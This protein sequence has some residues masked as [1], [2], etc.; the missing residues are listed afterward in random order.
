MQSGTETARRRGP[1][2]EGIS[3]RAYEALSEVWYFGQRARIWDRLVVSSGAR[4]GQR[5][6]ELGCGTGYFARRI[7]PVV[8]PSG[9]VVGIDPSLPS[10]AYAAA[11]SPPHCTFYPAQA[12]NLPFADASFDV[13]ASSLTFHHIAPDHR[14]VAIREALRVLRPGGRACIADVCPPRIRLLERVVS[15]AH[16][17]AEMHDI[18]DRLRAMMA[19]AGFTTMATGRVSRLCYIT[20]ERPH[21][22]TAAFADV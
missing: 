18:F 9:V 6:L 12:Q 20:A 14:L 11:H 19:E 15:A 3:P 17:R 21:D 7:A 8:G 5:V 16:G 1:R 13:V 2:S 4:P 10:L 22:L